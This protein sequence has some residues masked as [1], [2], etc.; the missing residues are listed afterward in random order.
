MLDFAAVGTAFGLVFVMETGDKT[1]LTVLTLASRS[2]RVL[3][4]VLGGSLGLITASLL[5]ALAGGLIGRLV[6][7]VWLSNAVGAIFIAAGLYM[8]WSWWRG[9][10]EN[11]AGMPKDVDR[12]RNSVALAAST[13]GIVFL[14]E[15]GDKTQLAVVGLAATSSVMEVFL[16]AALA[17]VLTT[18][19][20]A[21]TA[22]VIT[23]FM[24]VRLVS[25][26]AAVLFIAVGMLTLAGAF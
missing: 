12:A 22:K 2:G 21:L 26:G 9:G 1:Q 16:G 6:P 17:L 25:L 5:G 3:P 10:E 11:G 20:A 18:L 7:L 15:T 8:L 13:F 24:P 14:A 19:M 4:V 23:K